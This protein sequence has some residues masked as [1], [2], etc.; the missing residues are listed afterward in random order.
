LLSRFERCGFCQ[1]ALVLGGSALGIGLPAR[2][3][4]SHEQP[5]AD[6]QA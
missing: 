5:Y 6:G 1:G 4:G 3:F 2:G